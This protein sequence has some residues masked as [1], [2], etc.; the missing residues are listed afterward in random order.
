MEEVHSAVL[1]FR[2][3]SVKWGSTKRFLV[4]TTGVDG[5]EH[6][7]QCCSV[8]RNTRMFLLHPPSNYTIGS[9]MVFKGIKGIWPQ[10][11]YKCR[12]GKGNGC[13]AD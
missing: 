2:L 7:K 6:L 13:K 4:E 3:K 11:S 12:I 8:R 10:V 5:L 1:D 9:L